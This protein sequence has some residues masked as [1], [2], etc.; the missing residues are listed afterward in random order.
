MIPTTVL[1]SLMACTSEKSTVFTPPQEGEWKDE[2]P[3][4][5]EDNCDLADEDIDNPGV[6][7]IF[8]NILDLQEANFTF[9]LPFE[10]DVLWQE[11]EIP[12]ST[13]CSW[14]D[15]GAITCEE[16]EYMLIP[17]SVYFADEPNMPDMSEA[18]GDMAGILTIEELSFDGTTLK[19]TMQ[20]AFDCRGEICSELGEDNPCR[21]K[22]SFQDLLQEYESESE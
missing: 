7:P 13:S 16:N 21:I 8:I 17:L 14:D 15:A 12:P 19:G 3:V 6:T 5:Q 22:N 1:L 20:N 18:E 2:Q 11:D 9:A 4:I 10:N